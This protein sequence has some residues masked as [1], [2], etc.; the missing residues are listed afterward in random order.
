ML[1]VDEAHCISQWGQDFRPSY[2]KI[3]EFIK[4]LKK[5]PVISAF[6]AT[7]TEAV[8]NDIC[9]ALILNKP[10]ITL[11]GFNRPNLYFEVKHCS[12]KYDTLLPIIQSMKNKSGIIYCATRKN[13]EQVC[14]KLIRDGFKA[15][16]YHA[17]LTESERSKNQDD[18]LYDNVSLIVATNAFGMG[19]DKSNVGFV[20]HYNM[21]KDLESYYQEAGRAGRDGT[22]SDCI[23]LY[24][25]GDVRTN[26]LL[27]E[28]ESEHNLN[29]P[30]EIKERALERLKLMT[31]YCHTTECLRNYI[32]KYFGEK[33][34][35]RCDNCGNC[36]ADGV[37]TNITEDA[38]IICTAIQN[39]RFFYGRTTLTAILR[40]SKSS[41]FT[42]NN[43]DKNPA[44][45]KLKN[46]SEKEVN[47]RI[48]LLISKKILTVSQ[49]K[50]AVISPGAE[51]LT[52]E[53]PVTMKTITIKTS[54]SKTEPAPTGLF[55]RLRS[56]RMEIAKALGVPAFVIF[57]DATLTDMCTKL[58]RNEKEMLQVSGV[59]KT[60]FKRFGKD[61]LE[62]I[63]T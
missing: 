22:P 53:K 11:T 42:D 27:I 57:T 19:I 29:I 39:L 58:P 12:K 8:R 20:I 52:Y 10:Y 1:T 17:G 18:F 13:T 50:Y 51:F 40:G 61:F 4:L 46:L 3:C 26:Q 41:N 2:L 44:Y 33:Y 48:N 31:F 32:L 6:T 56:K 38:E 16:M 30:K 24:S 9:S 59:G 25:P 43:L 34:E 35:E 49:D 14:N 55:A 36:N 23:L 5:R 60:K 54:K 45:G 28:S 15:T 62:I 37:E 21:P 47:E 7:A 63:N